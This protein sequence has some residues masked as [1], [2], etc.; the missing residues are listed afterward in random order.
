MG[1]GAVLLMEKD[2]MKTI[3][4]EIVV[5]AS[6]VRKRVMIVLTSFVLS[7]ILLMVLLKLLEA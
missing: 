3:S 5:K 7:F 6:D 4:E 1:R 2:G